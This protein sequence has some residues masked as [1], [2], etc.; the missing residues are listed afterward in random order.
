M[1]YTFLAAQ[2]RQTGESLIHPAYLS[3]A[4]RLMSRMESRGI[5]LYLPEDHLACSAT[6]TNDSIEEVSGIDIPDHLAGCDIGD[7]T[8]SRWKEVIASA[9][10]IIWNGP[11]GIFEREECAKA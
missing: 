6:S 1:A 4:K 11:L 8:I 5:D 10:T 2:G 3:Q 9:G 7:K